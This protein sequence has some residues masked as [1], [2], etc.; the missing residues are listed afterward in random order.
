MSTQLWEA[1]L[2]G[3]TVLTGKDRSSGFER[4]AP[5]GTEG[6][7]VE[8]ACIAVQSLQPQF[9]SLFPLSFSVFR[10]C[11][12]SGIGRQQAA[13][14]CL[15]LV[16]VNDIMQRVSY[17]SR[18]ADGKPEG[19]SATRAQKVHCEEVIGTTPIV[20]EEPHRV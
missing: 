7:S 14:R 4:E 5:H 15:V 1:D 6:H 16:S 20:R 2:A 10:S 8:V 3:F 11:L 18:E 13:P 19:R 12:N 17:Q 9:S